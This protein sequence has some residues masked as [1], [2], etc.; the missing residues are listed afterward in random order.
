MADAIGRALDDPI[1]RSRL[2]AAGRDRVAQRFTWHAAARRTAEVY[3]R[4][5]DAHRV[6]R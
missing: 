6:I 1:L 4:A 2:G 3:R 5:I